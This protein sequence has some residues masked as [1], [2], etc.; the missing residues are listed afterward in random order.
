MKIVFVSNYYNHHQSALSKAF[1]EQTNGQYVFIQTMPMEE[2]RKNMGWKQPEQEIFVK[3]S[4]KSDKEFEECLGIINEADV[5]V[6]GSAP[7]KL[8]RARIRSGKLTFRYSER[9]YKNKKVKLQMPLR[10]IRYHINN[11]FSKNVYMLCASAYAAADYAKTGNFIGKTFK[12]GYFPEVKKY[13]DVDKLIKEKAPASIL[14]VARLIALKHPEACLE[15]AKKL[16]A[17]GYSFNLNIIGN[18]VLEE[19]LKKQIE[20]E[21]LSGCVHMLGMKP[22]DQVRS[23]MEKS[24]IFLFTSDFHEG[25][26]A[27]VNESMN[28]GCAVVA[29]HAAGVTP[30]LISDGENGFIYRSGDLNDLYK[31]VKYLLDN[32]DVRVSRGK[33]AYESMQEMWNPDTCA[34]RFLVLCEDLQKGGKGEVFESGPCSKAEILS[35]N[36]YKG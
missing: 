10:A 27:V 26:G 3:Q 20:E 12:W 32:P 29:S 33:A 5:V 25:W 8:V 15:V 13:Q 11:A 30:Y 35:N 36:W 21:N 6:V 24:E 19:S 7:E 1:Y 4:Y 31:K 9:V 23:Y 22:S 14:W 18:G 34:K 28:S 17:E 16:K 2:S